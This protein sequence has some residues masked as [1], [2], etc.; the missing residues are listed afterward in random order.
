M[1]IQ[2]TMLGIKQIDLFII[3]KTAS[4]EDF[5]KKFKA[6]VVNAYPDIKVD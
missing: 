1:M 4:K 2:L 5:L 6:D 3:G